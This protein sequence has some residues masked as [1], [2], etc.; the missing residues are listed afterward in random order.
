MKTKE[1]IKY[2]AKGYVYGNCWGGGRGAYSSEVLEGNTREEIEAQIMEG[3]KTGSL[4]SG[5]G[6]ESLIGAI[7][8]ITKNITI[9]V[10]GEEYT[11]TENE[12]NFYGDLTEEDIEFLEEVYFNS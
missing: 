11:R 4:D 7:M 12:Y 8:G 3:I 6:Y 1:K 2:I 10:G 5:M 9:E